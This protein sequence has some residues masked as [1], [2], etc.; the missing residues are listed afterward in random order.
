MKLQDWQ[1]KELYDP[2][3]YSI[4]IRTDFEI[5]VLMQFMVLDFRSV[6]QGNQ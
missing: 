3:D 2:N 6:D 4:L 1:K 5:W